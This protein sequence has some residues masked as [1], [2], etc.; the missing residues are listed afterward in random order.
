[1]TQNIV[2]SKLRIKEIDQNIILKRTKETK[3]L[4]F[5]VKKPPRFHA[6][7]ETRDSQTKTKN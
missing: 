3:N 7:Y 2:G 4:P 6:I 5:S 1:M